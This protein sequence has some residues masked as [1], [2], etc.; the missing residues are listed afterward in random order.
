MFQIFDIMIGVKVEG[1]GIREAVT[2]VISH[3]VKSGEVGKLITSPE[4]NPA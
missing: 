3:G 1:Q 2:L 4:F